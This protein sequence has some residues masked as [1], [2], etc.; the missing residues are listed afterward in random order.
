MREIVP[1][2]FTWPWFSERHGYDFNGYLIRHPEGNVAVDPAEMSE[3][4]LRE[5]VGG[6]VQRIVWTNR[7]HFRACAGKPPGA[8][9]LREGRSALQALVRSFP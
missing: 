2:I 5:L 6:R 8:P 9:V 1:S 7:D 3:G 4:V